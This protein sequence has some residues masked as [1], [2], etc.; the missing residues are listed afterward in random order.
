SWQHHHG[1]EKREVKI[2]ETQKRDMTKFRFQG[3][4]SK[5]FALCQSGHSR[6]WFITNEVGLL[7]INQ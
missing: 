6:S 1:N 7:R 5:N 2:L 4:R 3:G